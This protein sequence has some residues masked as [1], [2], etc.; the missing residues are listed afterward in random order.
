[1]RTARSV[2]GSF[3]LLAALAATIPA[4]SLA[5]PSGAWRTRNTGLET[6][7][8]CTRRA[9]RA[10]KNANLSAEASGTLGVLGK[11]DAIIVYVICM[12]GGRSA[13][14]FCSS[15]RKDSG[16]Y[17]AKMCDTVSRQMEP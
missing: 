17:T 4:P 2:L 9:F 10:M 6:D 7:G 5:Y 3:T 8:A 15:D 12:S 11:N 16:G 1:M 13:A 14:I